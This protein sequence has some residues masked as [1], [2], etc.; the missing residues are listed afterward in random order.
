MRDRKRKVAQIVREP[1]YHAHPGEGRRSNSL[2]AQIGLLFALEPVDA[3]PL[4]WVV[5]GTAGENGNVMPLRKR[6]GHERRILR[7]GGR[8]GREIFVQ[9]QDM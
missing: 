7:G 9:E 6:V 5:R 8:I 4:R 3:V 2:N 1:A